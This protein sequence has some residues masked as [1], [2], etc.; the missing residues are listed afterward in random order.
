MQSFNNTQESTIHSSGQL[1]EFGNY[2]L[3]KNSSA[4][5]PIIT[6]N[7]FEVPLYISNRL[8]L[9]PLDMRPF[10]DT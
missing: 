6:N 2:Y 4:G 5:K 10:T 7:E 9:L 8:A 3:R 1:E